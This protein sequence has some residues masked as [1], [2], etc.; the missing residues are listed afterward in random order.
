MSSQNVFLLERAIVKSLA[1]SGRVVI[2]ML[3]APPR[4]LSSGQEGWHMFAAACDFFATLRYHGAMG[5]CMSV[6]LQDG[7]MHAPLYRHVVA[8]LKLHYHEDLDPDRGPQTY[9]AREPRL[10]D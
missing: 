8:R 10:G 7:L 5:V 9:I 6:Y 2:A 4:S 3:M 1:P